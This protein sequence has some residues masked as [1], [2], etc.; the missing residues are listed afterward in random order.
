[1]DK[2]HLPATPRVNPRVGGAVIATIGLRA[3]R[4]QFE[5]KAGVRSVASSHLSVVAGCVGRPDGA[6]SATAA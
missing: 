1:M 3:G 6:N 2:G 4:V 5:R